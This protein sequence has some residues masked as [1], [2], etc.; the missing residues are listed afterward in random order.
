MVSRSVFM[1]KCT[2]RDISG[3]HFVEPLKTSPFVKSSNKQGFGG[4]KI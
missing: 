4:N 1:D 2:S 3:C